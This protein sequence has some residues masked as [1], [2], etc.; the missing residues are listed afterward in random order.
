MT[1]SPIQRFEQSMWNSPLFPIV[2]AMAGLLAIGG[3]A[4]VTL[5]DAQ[6]LVSHVNRV[7]DPGL[8]PDARA[9]LDLQI[10]I[11]AIKILMDFYLF[12]VITLVLA[13]G[14]RGRRINYR[15][16]GPTRGIE[17]AGYLLL[18]RSVN[19]IRYRLV[20]L[21]LARLVLGYIQQLLRLEY[22]RSLDL[23]YSVVVLL[24]V[25]GAFYLSH[26]IRSAA[27]Q[28]ALWRDV[29]AQNKPNG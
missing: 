5:A 6:L 20:G 11:E 17:Y 8:A 4:A 2:T 3:A 12:M 19:S 21:L 24:L 13:Y 27:R 28:P 7:A 10:A 25:G 23:A 15:S 9:P 22:D 29:P 18:T 1:H 14:V 16:P 26:H